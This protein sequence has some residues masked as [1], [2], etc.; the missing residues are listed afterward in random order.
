VLQMKK[1]NLFSAGVAIKGDER[2]LFTASGR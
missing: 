2:S 1:N